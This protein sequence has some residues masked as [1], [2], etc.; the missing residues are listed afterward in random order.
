MKEAKETTRSMAL[1]NSGKAPLAET[2]PST[3]ISAS[4]AQHLFELAKNVTK[5]QVTPETVR[6]ACACASEIHKLL[7]LQWRVKRGGL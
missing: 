5:D 4:L 6:A 3:P 1:L 2:P 7:D